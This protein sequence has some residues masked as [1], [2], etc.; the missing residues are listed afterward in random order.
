[1][2][3]C[4]EGWGPV[5]KG[6]IG[7]LDFCPCAITFA[8]A[9]MRVCGCT[10]GEWHEWLAVED[11]QEPPDSCPHAAALRAVI[12]NPKLVLVAVPPAIPSVQMAISALLAGAEVTHHIDYRP[13]GETDIWRVEQLRESQ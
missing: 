6:D 8:G 12:E 3:I 13:E 10:L 7:E 11:K 1:M 9:G 4:D 5:W 2:S